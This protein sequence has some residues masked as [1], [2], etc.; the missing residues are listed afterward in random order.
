MAKY[1]AGKKVQRAE[2]DY[3]DKRKR[4]NYQRERVENNLDEEVKNRKNVKEKIR[5]YID[6]G[7]T[8]EESADLITKEEKEL[9]ATFH[10]YTEAGV[11]IK[12]CF[13]NWCRK[14]K[15]RAKER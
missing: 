2:W 13:I 3:S 9:V 7:L 14:Y 1:N 5:G 10:Y 6:N 12:L 8:L 11:D 4:D 15:P